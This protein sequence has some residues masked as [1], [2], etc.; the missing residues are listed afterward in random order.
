MR[1][2]RSPDRGLFL[3]QERVFPTKYNEGTCVLDTGATNHMT[4]CRSSLT[5]L[6]DS[7]R[8]AMKFGDGSTVEI[9]GVGAVTI[10]G[11]N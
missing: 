8:G 6:D 1:T 7:V 11:K 2:P 5:S 9:H 10:A 3:N 4:G